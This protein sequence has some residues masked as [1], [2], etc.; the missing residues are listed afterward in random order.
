MPPD[1]YDPSRELAARATIRP[2]PDPA[3][4]RGWTRRA[5]RRLPGRA[6]PRVE[7]ACSAC[8][9]IRRALGCRVAALVAG[10]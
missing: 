8:A 10:C 5:A 1:L 6:P 7:A 4:P 9:L 3:G 2:A